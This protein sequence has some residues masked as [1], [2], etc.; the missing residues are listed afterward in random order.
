[1]PQMQQDAGWTNILR[2]SG[3]HEDFNEAQSIGAERAMNNDE[4]KFLIGR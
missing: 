1:M 3:V 2:T 4:A